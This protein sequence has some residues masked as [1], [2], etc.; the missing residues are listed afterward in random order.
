MNSLPEKDSMWYH[1]NGNKYTVL[2]IA[3]EHTVNSD[4][5][6]ITVVYQGENQ[7]IWSRP[8]S[9]WHRSMTLELGQ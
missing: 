6:P 2:F 3:N 7:K 1:S 9:D 5:Y 4:K 8:F